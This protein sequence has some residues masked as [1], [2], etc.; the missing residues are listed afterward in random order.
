MTENNALWTIAMVQIQSDSCI[1]V[2]ADRRMKE[3]MSN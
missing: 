2:Y 1:R 3:G